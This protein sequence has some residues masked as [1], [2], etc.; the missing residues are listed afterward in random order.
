MMWKQINEARMAERI[1]R[2][3]RMMKQVAIA[4]RHDSTV[5][6]DERARVGPRPSDSDI[7]TWFGNKVDNLLAN[8]TYGALSADSRYDEWI[9]RQYIQGHVGMEDISGEVIDALGTYRTLSIRGLLRP[10]DQDFNRFSSLVALQRLRR[11]PT[12]ANELRRL[13]DQA[14]IEKHRRAK[15]EVTL[16]DDDR[17]YVVIPLN[18]G[19]CYTFNN[20]A[21]VQANFC[22]GGSSGFT[23]FNN[24]APNG[25][26]VSIVDKENVNE[27]DGKWQFHA[28]TNQLVN[29]QQDDRG[30][31]PK[32]DR[33]FAR[34]FPGLMRRIVDAIVAHED[35]I[36]E[37]SKNVTKNGYDIEKSVKEIKNRF[38]ISYASEPPHETEPE[39]PQP[40]A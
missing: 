37:K 6:P 2:D 22:T 18:Y 14:E 23:W 3:P 1:Q 39:T 10:N 28:P 20:A 29:S 24:Y 38:P 35:E 12:Y 9:T 33:K 26:I 32:N 31:I 16:I 4:F 5:E 40:M 13:K 19:S 25:P 15:I 11:D 17:F 34:L 27:V 21:G 36:K 8:S 7:A 30:D